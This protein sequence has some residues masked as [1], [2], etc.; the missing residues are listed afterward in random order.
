MNLE[1]PK[2]LGMTSLEWKAWGQISPS[3]ALGRPSIT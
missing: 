2:G 1:P 3:S